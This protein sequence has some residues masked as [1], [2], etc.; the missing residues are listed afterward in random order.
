LIDGERIEILKGLKAGESVVTAGLS[1]LEDGAEV[2]V[3]EL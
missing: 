3:T 1:E 2:K